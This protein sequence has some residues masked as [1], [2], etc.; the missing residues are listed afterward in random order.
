MRNHRAAWVC[1][2]A[3]LLTGC[4]AKESPSQAEQPSETTP[5]EETTASTAPQTETEPVT[6]PETEP[7]PVYQW[8]VEPQFDYDF[9]GVILQGH[10]TFSY[11]DGYTND[12]LDED[13]VWKNHFCVYSKD[14]YF[15]I[16]DYDGNVITPP[17]YE[18]VRV[19]IGEKCILQQRDTFL[20]R[21]ILQDGTLTEPV[22]GEEYQEVT[23]GWPMVYW[24]SDQNR[25]CGCADGMVDDSPVAPL[26]IYPVKEGHEER[27]AKYDFSYF[28]T[29]WE[30]P[31]A[32]ASNDRLISEFIYE[33]AGRYHEGVIPVK[34]DGKWGY[35]DENGE[36]V[37]PFAYDDAWEKNRSMKIQDNN[38]HYARWSAYDATEGTVVLCK[39][40]D[41]ALYSVEGEEIIPFGE[42]EEISPLYQGKAWAKSGGKWGVI[43]LGGDAAPAV[44]PVEEPPSEAP[45]T[46]KPD[47][48]DIINAYEAKI[49]EK[50][51]ASRAMFGSDDYN[52]SYALLDIC[53]DSIPEL[54][55]KYGTCEADFQVCV[56]TYRDGGVQEIGSGI[57]AGHATFAAD[58]NSGQLVMAGGHMGVQFLRWYAPG[59]DG[60]LRETDHIQYEGNSDVYAEYQIDAI[61]YSY[62]YRIGD[63]E[64]SFIFRLNEDE[65]QVPGLDLSLLTEYPF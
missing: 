5:T 13:T 43:A 31:Y 49:M 35:V 9:A 18:E 26:T 22:S 56:Y 29:D 55:V 62:S 51:G 46:E 11:P 27:D 41:Y 15:G 54:A 34:K 6:E 32:L 39:D 44:K 30:G 16:T 37:I 59:E 36:T 14:G 38:G 19:G 61:P 52:M 20:C 1:A 25:I 53:G 10:V 42:L 63:T 24:N 28:K 60:I 21:E 64:Q 33:D 48:T 12:Y 17:E 8:A 45:L 50:V 2:L 7:A 58:R 23:N 3:L 40:G 57:P 47:R 65:Q 4:S